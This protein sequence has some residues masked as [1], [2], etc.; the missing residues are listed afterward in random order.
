MPEVG[1][2]KNAPDI[3]LEAARRLG[4]KAGECI[5]FEDVLYAA[6]TAKRAG[7]RVCA[8]YDES[9]RRRRAELEAVCDAYITGFEDVF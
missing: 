6:E 2:G 4:L 8:V 5:V 9:Q 1:R 7:F 3:Y